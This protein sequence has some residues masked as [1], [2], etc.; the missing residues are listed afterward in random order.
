MD[1]IKD[2]ER[3]ALAELAAEERAARV[4]AAKE[5]IRARRGRPWWDKLIP[6]T[7]TITRK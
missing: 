6:F 4:A 5:R 1:D 7:I 3:E 2:I